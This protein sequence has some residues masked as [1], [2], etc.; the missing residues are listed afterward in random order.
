M[1]YGPTLYWNEWPGAP[2][3]TP[4][5]QMGK[6]GVAPDRMYKAPQLLSMFLRDGGT[7]PCICGLTVR[8]SVALQV[9]GFDERIQNLYEDQIFLAKICSQ[10]PVYV[11]SGCWDQYRQHPNSTSHFAIASAA[12]IQREQIHRDRF[13]LAARRP[14]TNS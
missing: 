4:R 14:R 5:D 3:R 8:R 2:V 12:I 1:A 9:G 7:V 13:L 6:L 10:F 11:E